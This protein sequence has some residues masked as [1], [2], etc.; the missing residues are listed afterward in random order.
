MGMNMKMIR[1]FKG[2]LYLII[3]IL[4]LIGISVIF[5]VEMFN[6]VDEQYKV[7]L[8]E[9]AN[10]LS[11]EVKEKINSSIMYL[12]GLSKVFEKFDD[13]HCEEAVNLLIDAAKPSEF[14]R[15]WLTKADGSAISSEGIISNAK[16]REYLADGIKGNSG[17]SKSQISNVN[18]ER[19]VVIYAPIYRDNKVVGLV[20]GI[21]ALDSLQGIVDLE[22]FDGFG[23]SSIY[24]NSQCKIEDL[25]VTSHIG[26]SKNIK[27]TYSKAVGINKWQ[28]VIGL[29]DKVVNG[30]IN[31][32]IRISIYACIMYIFVIGIYAVLIYKRNSITLKN[33]AERDSLTMLLNRGTIEKIINKST[34]DEKKN[35]AMIVFDVDKFKSINDIYGHIAGDCIL[36]KVAKKMVECFS[37]NVKLARL[38]GDEFCIYIY[39]YKNVESILMDLNEFKEEVKN[40][41]YEEIELGISV[42]IG[43]TFNDEES[44]NFMDM[45]KE[46][47]ALMYMSKKSGGDK[48]HSKK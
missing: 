25:L 18:G 3:L 28:L 33:R 29:P 21:F 43:V 24:E 20:I 9:T 19:N 42:S 41:K 46:A 10:R 40:I 27:Y 36:K 7:R 30:E 23:Y 26:E 44:V 32:N 1:K 37:E 12:N 11:L 5:S 22:C 31:K 15:M 17:V 14:T 35:S 4:L 45:Y 39:K 6:K 13:I 2:K 34:Y 47:D 48:I 16:D 8:E 38:G